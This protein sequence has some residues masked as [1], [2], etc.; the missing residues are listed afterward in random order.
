[1]SVV[2]A[3]KF[4]NGVVLASDRQVTSYGSF[5]NEDKANKIIQS[6]PLAFGG[7]GSLR[8]LQ[9]MFK[10]FPDIFN[11]S[12]AK[13]SN[14]TL[15]ECLEA[16]NRITIKFREN[17]FIEHSQIVDSLY[18][19]FV[20]A[21]AYNIFSISSCLSVMSDFDY[22]SVGSGFPHVM[23]NL[24]NI[25]KDKKPQ[26]MEL[27]DI[28]NI[29][30]DSIQVSCKDICSIDDNIDFIILY[31]RPRDLQPDSDIEIINKCEFDILSKKSLKTKKEC[32]TNCKDCRH[33]M[34]IVYSK[35]DKTIKGIS[36]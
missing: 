12:E 17:L 5:K 4:K 28:I 16:V 10:I 23:G 35:K 9:Q 15:E 3:C 22:Y 1:M 36:N 29:L 24:N 14:L 20:V 27:E 33:N 13:K 19:D 2:I 21:D 32:G 26:D 34:R 6:G 25:F 31:K 18:G 8:E 11:I 30:K 7:V